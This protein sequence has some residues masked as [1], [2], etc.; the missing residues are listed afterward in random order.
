VQVD[1]MK[2]TMKV[3]ISERLN[4]ECDD[5]LSNFAFNFK[6]G[7]YSEAAVARARVLLDEA[8]AEQVGTRRSSSNLIHRLYKDPRL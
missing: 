2:P 3:P 1:P 5:L 6:L 8:A 7:R 4:L